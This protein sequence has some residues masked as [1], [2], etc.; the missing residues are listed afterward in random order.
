MYNE[1]ENPACIGCEGLYTKEEE[2]RERGKGGKGGDEME[3]ESNGWSLYTTARDPPQQR[4][5]TD[6]F[7]KL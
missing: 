2:R 5:E 7:R 1:S 3:W 4:F 6:H